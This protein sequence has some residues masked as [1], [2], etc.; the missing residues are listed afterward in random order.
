MQSSRCTSLQ[1]V[2]HSTCFRPPPCPDI[3]WRALNDFRV[4][5]LHAV[6]I[7]EGYENVAGEAEASLQR[8]LELPKYKGKD[9][10]K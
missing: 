3:E 6:L 5:A 10:S 1:R 8:L 9:C 2:G 7:M 4:F